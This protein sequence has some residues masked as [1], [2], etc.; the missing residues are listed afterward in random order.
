MN[1]Q[2]QLHGYKMG[3]SVL[4]QRLECIFVYICLLFNKVFRSISL[5]PVVETRSITAFFRKSQSETEPKEDLKSAAMYTSPVQGQT[6]GT[7]T[8]QC[9]ILLNNNIFIFPL[10]LSNTT[11]VILKKQKFLLK[12]NIYHACLLIH[13]HILL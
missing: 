1:N 5:P 11:K 2:L 10:F 7:P 9:H 12:L 3:I 13:F 8:T 6:T 4:S